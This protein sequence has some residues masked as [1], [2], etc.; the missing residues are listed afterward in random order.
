MKLEIK[1]FTYFFILMGLMLAGTQS[2]YAGNLSTQEILDH[3]KAHQE[4]I[5]S[6]EA[7]FTMIVF[8]I[9]GMNLE[10]IGHY[11]YAAPDHVLMT[12]TKPTQQV[13]KTENGKSYMSIANG[14]FQEIPVS[15][16]TADMNADLFQNA[17]LAQ[18]YL[19]IDTATPPEKGY[20]YKVIGY[21][22]NKDGGIATSETVRNPK[23]VEIIYDSNRGL[24]TQMNFTGAGPMP[25]ME[26]KTVYEQKD[27]CW[28]PKSVFTRVITPA[29]AIASVVQLENKRIT[30]IKNK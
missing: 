23:A 3:L 5:Q 1:H 22:K 30:R 8:G 2:V 28:V 19:E 18:F 27:G 21:H 26:V 10:H 12:Y 6:I 20:L 11:S 24:V 13:I 4:K 7:D 15:S 16:Q 14:P 25:P 17:F 9:G 29:G